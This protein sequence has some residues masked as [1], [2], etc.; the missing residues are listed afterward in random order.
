MCGM[1]TFTDCSRGNC[2]GIACMDLSSPTMVFDSIRTSCSSTP[3][4]KALAGQVDWSAPIFPYQP[5]NGDADLSFDE[6]DDAAGMQKCVVVNP[7]FDWEEDRPLCLPLSDSIIYELHVK[8]FTKRHPEIPEALRGTY[9]GLAS[10][11]SIQYLKRLGVTAVELMPVHA[12]LTDK[13]L[14]EKGLT[15]YWGYNTTNFFS[16]DARYSGSG[17]RGGQVAE[18]KSHGE[19]PSTAR[20][21][22]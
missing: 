14:A 3:T 15:N 8:G 6:N 19:E 7:Y 17:D 2:T 9:A 1:A 5:G 20:A 4:R 16:P 13:H 11:P 22:K 21:S 18:F 12:F 10:K